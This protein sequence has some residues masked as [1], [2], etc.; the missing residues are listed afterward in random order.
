VLGHIFFKQ[1]LYK[2]LLITMWCADAEKYKYQW[3]LDS[4]PDGDETG[5]MT[6]IDSKSLKLSKVAK[7]RIF[8]AA[9]AL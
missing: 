3:S 2:P 4:H 7:I 8:V 6:D 9:A 5:E 1:F